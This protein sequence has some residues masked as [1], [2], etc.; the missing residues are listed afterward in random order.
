MISRP[1]I[2]RKLHFCNRWVC[3]SS[4]SCF[5]TC[6]KPSICLSLKYFVTTSSTIASGA[7]KQQLN[8]SDMAK[9]AALAINISHYFER[10][11]QLLN[12][13]VALASQ[14][15]AHGN[16]REISKLDRQVVA[17]RYAIYAK[18]PVT[19]HAT[20]NLGVKKTE[21]HRTYKGCASYACNRLGHISRDYRSAQT[22]EQH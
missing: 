4:A 12:C 16:W 14:D 15:R 10:V 8:K 21:I 18:S 17:A 5:Q 7:D 9:Y 22:L 1:E 2:A 6:S 19:Y 13:S 3:N 11:R 20:V